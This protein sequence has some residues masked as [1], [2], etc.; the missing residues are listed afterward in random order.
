MS[1]SSKT[2]SRGIGKWKDINELRTE[3]LELAYDDRIVV[4]N[5]N[6]DIPIG[7]ITSL[8]G[9]NGSGKSTILKSL[10]R[11]LRPKKGHVILDGTSI[12]QI[13][14]KQV[15]RRMAILPQNPLA[16][17]GL[18][19]ERLVWHGRYPHQGFLGTSSSEDVA[20]VAWALEQARLEKFASRPLDALSGGERQ[21]AWIAMALA[22][23]TPVVLLDEPT[24]FL[25]I[26]HQFEVM[27]LLR[28]LNLVHGLTVVIVLHDLNQAA[29]FSDHMMVLS[30]GKIWR[31]GSP[32]K[33]IDT[34]LLRDVFGIQADVH[35]DSEFNKPYFLPRNR[36]S[37]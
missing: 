24:T 13:P 37:H 34:S 14:T 10:S 31:E 21:R 7:K 5:L 35:I 8:V 29:R 27:E 16:P 19:V 23:Q 6:I 11:L 22:Q 26:G 3:A 9:P 4:Q 20:A 36:V 17:E 12:Q 33:V 25:D 32:D 18:T 2:S 15:A 1:K 30:E 28:E